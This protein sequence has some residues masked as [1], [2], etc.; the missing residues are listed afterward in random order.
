MIEQELKQKVGQMIMAGFPSPDFD[1][2]ARRLLEDFQI[3]NFIYF[4]RNMQSAA[5]VNI[6]LST[7][8][9]ALRS[10]SWKPGGMRKRSSDPD[11]LSGRMENWS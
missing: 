9:K 5:Q 6:F 1:E 2:Q 11:R 7:M 8:R 4:S 3:G 10:A